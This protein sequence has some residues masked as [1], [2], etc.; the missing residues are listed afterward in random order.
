MTEYINLG[1]KLRP[2]SFAHRQQRHFEEIFNK[3]F[4]RE[5]KKLM[6]QF[7]PILN[8]A[9]EGASTDEVIELAA[10][11]SIRDL[12]D[13][14]YSAAVCG[15][16]LEKI[17]V[18]FDVYDFT[19]WIVENQDSM[20]KLTTMFFSANTSSVGEATVSAPQKKMTARKKIG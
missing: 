4:M 1:G 9:H 6:D 7:A 20:Q 2:V 13:Q 8:K 15:H 14:F 10:D 19:D 16:H 3:P 5:L 12:G 11:I 17:P 18:D